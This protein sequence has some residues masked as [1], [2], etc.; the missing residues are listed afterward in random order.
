MPLHGPQK[1]ERLQWA[2]VGHLGTVAGRGAPGG[3]TGWPRPSCVAVPGPELCS[4]GWGWGVM[5]G[6]WTWF[7]SDG[8]QDGPWAEEGP[9]GPVSWGQRWETLGGWGLEEGKAGSRCPGHPHLEPLPQCLR[10][11]FT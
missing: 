9:S 6:V 5:G 7:G 4:G 1:R 11:L 3:G 8:D 2:L 10:A